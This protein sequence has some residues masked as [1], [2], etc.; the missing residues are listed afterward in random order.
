MNIIKVLS[1]AVIVTGLIICT[2]G[3]KYQGLARYVPSI[4]PSLSVR[5]QRLG[6]T[7]KSIDEIEH[8]YGLDEKAKGI[9][10]AIA[11]QESNGRIYA[12]KREPG[13]IGIDRRIDKLS[14]TS[15][16]RR[17]VLSTSYGPFQI[18]GVEAAVRGIPIEELSKLPES[19]ELAASILGGHYAAS[20]YIDPAKRIKDALMKWN[21][22]GCGRR[23]DDPEKNKYAQSVFK[24]WTNGKS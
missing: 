10:Q 18:L 1:S 16:L 9:L 21:C 20:Q 11:I 14:G 22:W 23:G 7:L 3:W 8:A 4:S 6:E 5:Y 12:R 2:L 15:A 19:A 24:I 17:D 13:I